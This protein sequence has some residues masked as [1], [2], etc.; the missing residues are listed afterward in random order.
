MSSSAAGFF[1]LVESEGFTIWRDRVPVDER[2]TGGVDRS[3]G[4]ALDAAP[5]DAAAL[6]AAPALDAEP[7]LDIAAAPP[8]EAAVSAAFFSSSD[9]SSASAAWRFFVSSA[10][11]SK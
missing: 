9:F 6:D 4:R 1:S 5:E 3:I 10:Q 7:A 8:A 2:V 11:R